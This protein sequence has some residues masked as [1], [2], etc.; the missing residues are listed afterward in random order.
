MFTGFFFQNQ[1]IVVMKSPR[2]HPETNGQ[3]ERMVRLVKNVFKKS[4]VD[5]QIRTLDTD[6]QISYFLINSRNICLETDGRFPSERMLSYKPKILFDL[7]NPKHS[8]KKNL[9]NVRDDHQR[10]ID[11]N[12]SDRWIW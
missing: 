5:P 2:Y 6:E 11:S 1:G 3:A 9:T 10:C 7:I 4:L 8:Y 12:E